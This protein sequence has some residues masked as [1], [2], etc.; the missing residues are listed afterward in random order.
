MLLTIVNRHIYQDDN[1]VIGKTVLKLSGLEVTTVLQKTQSEAL[2]LDQE[3]SNHVEDCQYGQLKSL[4][5][6]TDDLS[7]RCLSLEILK[8]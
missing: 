6:V 7:S 3:S 5:N 1:D 4:L 8:V 2:S